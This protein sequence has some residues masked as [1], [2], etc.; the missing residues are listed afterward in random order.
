MGKNSYMK[1][2]IKLTVQEKQDH[3]IFHIG[4]NELNSNRQLEL[5]S[6]LI[7]NQACILTSDSID[8][9]IPNN[10]FHTDN[11][12]ENGITVISHLKLFCVEMNVFLEETQRPSNHRRL[13]KANNIYTKQKVA[14]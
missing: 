12:N 9:S 3:V 10:I 8:A 6:K 5:I 2:Y 11:N 14:F 7:V 13:I 4:T 1:D